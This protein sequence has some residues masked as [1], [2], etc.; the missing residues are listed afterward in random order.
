MSAYS[1][2]WDLI[3]TLKGPA[4]GSGTFSSEM[5]FKAISNELL[6]QIKKLDPHIEFKDP[7]TLLSL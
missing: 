7:E 5:T 2:A 1:P 6:N 4:S 3:T